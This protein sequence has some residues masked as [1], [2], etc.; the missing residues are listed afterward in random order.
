MDAATANTICCHN[1]VGAEYA[2]Y[3][4]TTGFLPLARA[5]AAAPGAPPMTF[6]DSTTGIPLFRA[7][8][9]RTWDE[10]ISESTHHGWPSFRYAEAILA[11]LRTDNGEVLASGFGEVRSVNGTHLGHNIPDASGDRYCIDLVCIAG[12]ASPQISRLP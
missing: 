6:Y 8:V 1:T 7:P 2:G 11:N 9:N 12:T 5:A 4:A 10:F 3:W